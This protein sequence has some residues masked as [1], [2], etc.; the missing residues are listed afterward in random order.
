MWWVYIVE[1][2]DGQNIAI[3]KGK[4]IEK[5]IKKNS[6]FKNSFFLGDTVNDGISANQNKLKFIRCNYGYGSDQ[7]WSC[8]S[9]NKS[10]ENF[11]ELESILI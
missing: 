6:A 11:K 9:I 10:I 5:I 3:N 2:S 4:M 8:V 7:D 1:C